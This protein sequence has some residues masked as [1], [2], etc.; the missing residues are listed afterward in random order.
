[1]TALM[2]M[3]FQLLSWDPGKHITRHERMEHTW[4]TRSAEKLG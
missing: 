1:M 3:C 2:G 4:G